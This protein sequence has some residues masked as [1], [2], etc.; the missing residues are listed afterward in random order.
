M[1]AQQ[2]E[3]EETESGPDFFH[4]WED[5]HLPKNKALQQRHNFNERKIEDLKKMKNQD[6][7]RNKWFNKEISR[8]KSE[9]KKIEEK[10]EVRDIE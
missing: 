8:L 1:I 10:I 6:N 4:G 3:L 7:T 2:L 9:N 5:K